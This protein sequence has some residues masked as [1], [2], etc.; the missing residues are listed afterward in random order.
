MHETQD[1][2]IEH[3]PDRSLRRLLQDREYVRGLVYIIAPE[4]AAFL[5]FD[6]ITY[7]KRSFISEALRERESDVLLSVPFQDDTDALLIYILIEH[8][9]TVDKTMGFR[10][11][12]YMV[13]IW[14]SQRLEWETAKLPENERRLQPILPILFY[15]GER[16]WRVPVSVKTL[17]DA[18]EILERFVPSFDTLFLGVKETEAEVLTQFE[19]PLG[20][21]LRVLQK[22]HAEETEISEALADAMSHIAVLDEN[23]APQVT[24]ALRYF[25]QLIY[26]RRSVDERDPLVSII[27]EQRI[28]DPKELETMAQTTAE[29][30]R[31]QGRA[32]GKVEGRAEGQQDA[33]LKLLQLRFQNVPEMLSR[34]IRNI[35]NLTLLDA[36][37]EQAMTVQNLEEIDTQFSFNANGND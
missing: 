31:E 33:L 37:L 20:W 15:T 11:L 7:Q 2:Q 23:F 21:L 28:R 10:L 3:F 34:E 8:Q 18:P 24:E 12:S 19:H 29:F 35:D 25:L 13:Q 27:K 6:K 30:L 9:S 5:D 36:L 1:T 32:E 16:P 4:I 17:M 26:H 14:E 22:E